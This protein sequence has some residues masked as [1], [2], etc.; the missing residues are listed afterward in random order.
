MTI[1][2]DIKNYY[3]DLV[4]DEIFRRTSSENIKP[5]YYDDIACVA[6]NKLPPKYY[7]FSVDIAF[8][9]S[10]QEYQDMQKQVKV[11]V[12]EAIAFVDDHRTNRGSRANAE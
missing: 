10:G 7:R 4:V 3:E 8:Y 1:E 9:L 11:A 2:T 6:L 12:D 5:E